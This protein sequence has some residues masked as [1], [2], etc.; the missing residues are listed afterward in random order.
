MPEK[1][2]SV[3]KLTLSLIQQREPLIRQFGA[4]AESWWACKTKGGP[5]ETIALSL[6]S[7]ALDTVSLCPAKHHTAVGEDD[8]H[9]HR[10]RAA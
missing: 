4:N 5:T 9:Y 6:T 3:R 2:Q 8:M 7:P 10:Q 1:N